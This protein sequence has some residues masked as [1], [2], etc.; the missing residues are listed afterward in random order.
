LPYAQLRAGIELAVPCF[1]PE[2]GPGMHSVLIET[3]LR[4][5][6]LRQQILSRP[7]LVEV[8]AAPDASVGVIVAPPGF[9]KTTLLA[10]WDASDQRP[11]AWLSLD[12]GENDPLVF[13]SHIVASVRRVDPDFGSTVEPALNSMGGFAL[14]AVVARIL[15]ELDALDQP[16]V[17]V[18]D[19]YQRISSRACHETLGLFLERLPPPIQLIISTRSDPPLPLGRLRASGQLT[20]L[21]GADLAFTEV[22]TS[23]TMNGAW[24]LGLSARSIALLHERT[25]GWPACLYLASL[26]LRG[27]S[28]PADFIATFSGATRVVID[29]LMEVVF[30]QQSEEVRRF[31]METSVLER[32]CGSLCDAVTGGTDSADLLAELEHENLFVIPLDDRRDWFRFHHLF[33]QALNEELGRLDGAKRLMLHRRAGAWFEARG[34]VPQAI[35]HAFAGDDL[36]SAA[37]LVATSSGLHL[38]QGRLTTVAGWLEMFPRPIIEADARLLLVEG[39]IAGLQGDAEGGLRALS[40]A[41][42]ASHGE[43]QPDGSGTVEESATLIRATFPWSDVGA[44]LSAARAADTRQR[45]RDSIWQALAALNLGWA[46]I[47]AGELEGAQEPLVRA[48][49]FAPS[50]E[51]WLAAGDARMLLAEVSLAADDVG[52]AE[53]WIREAFEVATEHGFVDLPHVGYYHVVAGMIHARTGELEEADRFMSDGLRQMRGGWEPI[54]VAHALL[55]LA[56]VRRALGAPQ[57]ARAMI[58]E[59]RAVIEAS[60]DAGILTER[61]EQAART[62]VPAYRRADQ[63]TGLTERE[64]EVLRVLAAGSTEREAAVTL[65]VARSTI[66]SH[67]KS[68]YFKLGCSS[69]GEALVRAHELGLI[70]SEE[71]R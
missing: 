16:I 38:N 55:A 71:I 31:L 5:P 12:E 14:D 13:W 42:S 63:D 6:G 25:E 22:E 60:P 9:G 43:E 7:R 67:T 49:A 33:A 64:L 36:D 57:E 29:Y 70:A 61:L 35:E 28:D 21:R 53:A 51:Q 4:V 39:W 20:E 32:M 45:E 15:N 44:M 26:S 19:D 41:R 17:L 68:I 10:Q 37:T 34:E 27:A 24:G 58:E 3:K 65:F 54:H 1:P 48:V 2:S 23:E 11:F 50:G 47:L 62:L 66:H 30:E 69:R 59:A 40:E 46:L 52:E 56:P 18:L 8:L